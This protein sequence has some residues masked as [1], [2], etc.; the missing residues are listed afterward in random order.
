MRMVTAVGAAV[1]HWDQWQNTNNVPQLD[2][3]V[4]PMGMATMN[5]TMMH[6]DR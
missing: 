1:M 4:L 6:T 2:L 5:L 3:G